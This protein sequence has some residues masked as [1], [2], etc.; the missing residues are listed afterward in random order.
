MAQ[1]QQG[2]IH[3]F[4]TSDDGDMGI[5]N[6]LVQMTGGLET[7]AYLCLFGGN[8][9]DDGREGGTKG[10]WGNTMETDPARKMVSLTQNLLTSIPA[11]P[12]NLRR[13]ESAAK[14]DLNVFISEKIASE[15]LVSASIPAINR[16]NVKISIL[17]FGEEVT[18]N[19]TENW[20]VSI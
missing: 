8:E 16:V 14:K 11:T 1:L 20:N 13:I 5:Q 6:G 10:Y 2:D 12:A 18:F 19:F 3:I 9:Q 15:V 7:M 17:A 4:Q